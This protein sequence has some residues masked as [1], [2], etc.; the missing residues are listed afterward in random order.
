[1]KDVTISGYMAA[2]S[3]LAMGGPGRRGFHRQ[4]GPCFGKR[5]AYGQACELR[6]AEYRDGVFLLGFK[7]RLIIVQAEC[8]EIPLDLQAAL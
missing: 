8:S 6:A 1:M 3:K 5:Q 4:S 2:D 7:F